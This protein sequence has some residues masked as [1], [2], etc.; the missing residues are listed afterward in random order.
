MMH[1]LYSVGYLNPGA[2]DLL[3]AHIQ[4]A[5]MVVAIRLVAGSRYRPEFS[6]KRLRERFGTSYQRIRSLSKENY[7]QPDALIMLRDPGQGIPQLLALLA[8]QDVCLL[9]PCRQLARCHTAVVLAELRRI[10][11]NVQLL[12]LGEQ[13]TGEEGLHHV[14]FCTEIEGREDSISGDVRSDSVKSVKNS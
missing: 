11:P 6:A 8:Q 3:Q 10:C 5:A 4:Q 14:S 2:L 1:D 7:N 9:C 13:H 12:C